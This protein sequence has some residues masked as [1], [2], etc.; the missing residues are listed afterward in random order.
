MTQSRKRLRLIRVEL[1]VHLGDDVV[2]LVDDQDDVA[3]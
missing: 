1:D 3:S 2:L